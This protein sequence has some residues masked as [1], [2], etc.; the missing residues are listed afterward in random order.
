MIRKQ[1]FLLIFYVIGLSVPAAAQNLPTPA[2]P[3]IG[4]K[5]YLVVDSKSGHEIAAL[6]ADV[7][8]APA[9]LTKIMTTYVIFAALQQGQITLSEEVTI[10]ET[11]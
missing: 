11:A 2:P 1:L 4:A 5:S 7:P 10:R 9:S 6:D 3:I 8:L